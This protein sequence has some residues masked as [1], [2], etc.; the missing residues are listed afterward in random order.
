MK[1]RPFAFTFLLSLLSGLSLFS[2]PQK[3]IKDDL[4][5]VFV[6]GAPP[7]RIISLAPNITEILFALELG[8]K[9][10]G[11]T[12]YCDYPLEVQE[13]EKIGGMLDLDLEKI[14]ALNP[15]LIIGFRGNPLSTLKRLQ[16]LS[17]RVFILE[18][19]NDLESVFV[20]IT[21][22]GRITQR[23]SEAERLLQ[24]KKNAY[25]RTL[26]A[27]QH[28]RRKPRVFLA[29]HGLGLWTC[30]KESF[31]NDLLI[32]AGSLNVTGN[33]PKK[34]IHYSQEKLILDAPE[35]IIILAKSKEDFLNA[36]AWFKE[37]T[38]FDKI[39]AVKADRIHFLDEN[40]ASRYGP[41]LI[42]AFAEAARLIH[43]E[44]FNSDKIPEKND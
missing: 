40:L 41:R 6:I 32:K 13:K 38:G 24:S 16:S 29:L 37:R 17:G 23:E 27:L 14:K 33:I 5:N 9:I 11:V 43:P 42:D 30:G 15:D 35:I 34:W 12:R 26:A 36:R 19:G 7:Q 31:L 18:Q 8:D 20:T 25:E 22:I 1:L 2:G 39:P 3:F 21:K 10:V 44:Q 28:I 4:G